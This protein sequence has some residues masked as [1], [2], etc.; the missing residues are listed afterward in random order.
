MESTTIYLSY[1]Y[2]MA[3]LI[4]FCYYELILLLING[5]VYF[6]VLSQKNKEKKKNTFP[7][8]DH[9]KY[10]MFDVLC[11]VNFSVV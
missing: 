9:F 3:K 7:S 4:L 8:F 6:T 11:A 10:E 5:K 1:V 2:L